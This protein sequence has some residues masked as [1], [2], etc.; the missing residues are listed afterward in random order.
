MTLLVKI[1]LSIVRATLSALKI[2]A[3]EAPTPPKMSANNRQNVTWV[4]VRPPPLL[5]PTPS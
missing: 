5:L 2:S 4:E 3:A 1:P